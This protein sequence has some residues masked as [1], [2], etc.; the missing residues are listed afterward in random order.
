VSEPNQAGN[1]PGDAIVRWLLDPAS[2]PHRPASVELVETHIS[3]V[4]LAGDVVYKRKKPVQ[5]DFVDFSTLSARHEACEAEL[6]LNRR[7]APDVYLGLESVTKTPQGELELGNSGET[8]DWLV[9]MRRIDTDQSLERLLVEDRLAEEQID[10]LGELLREFYGGVSRMEITSEEYQARIEHHVRDNSRVL[11]ESADRLPDSA[12]AHVHSAQLQFLQLHA[13]SIASRCRDGHIVDGHGDLRPEHICFDPKP[14][15]FDCLE[16][17]AEFRTIDLLDEL[18]FLAMECDRLG[19]PEVGDAILR[20]TLDEPLDVGLAQLA[21]FY[22]CYRAC[23]RAKV[24]ALRSSQH[25]GQARKA[26]LVEAAAYLELA[27][28]YAENFARR[29]LIVVRGLMGSGKSTLARGL[30]DV[31]GGKHL[32]TDAIRQE[33]FTSSNDPEAY[34]EGK[35]DPSNRRRVYDQMFDQARVAWSETYTVILDGTFLSAD[36][37]QHAAQ[38]AKQAGAEF[39]LFRCHCPPDVARQRIER[40]AEQESTLSEARP[41]LFARQQADEQP[42]PGGM[43]SIDVDS[44]RLPEVQ[45]ATALSHLGD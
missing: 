32:E 9:K 35:Y 21:S 4:F 13:S 33:M 25:D 42:D 5:F 20:R 2:Y 8:V 45:L 37:R 17:S 6:R 11:G 40:R 24:D 28:K 7:L 38:V 16:F 23:V 30:A 36:L 44:T 3:W 27:E 29:Q 31:L 22:K 18:C 10:A 34:G 19:A 1:E 26:D 15:V 14:L 43:K 12:V 41:E 39:H